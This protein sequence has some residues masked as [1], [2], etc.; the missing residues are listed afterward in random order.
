M[1]SKEEK[2]FYYVIWEL[3]N[4]SIG[5]SNINKIRYGKEASMHLHVWPQQSRKQ[6]LGTQF[7]RM[8]LSHY[9]EQFQLMVLYCEPNAL[10]EVPNKTLRKVGFECIEQREMVPGWINFYQ[11]INRYR[12]TRAQYEILL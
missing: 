5:H 3:D 1:G 4:E 10:N 11:P 7:V 12:M 6:G 9:F 8:T 2:A